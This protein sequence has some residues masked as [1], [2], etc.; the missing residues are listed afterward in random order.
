MIRDGRR[1]E[2]AG[3]LEPAVAVRRAHHGNLDALIAQA[4]DTSGPFSFDRGPSFELEA[5]LAKEI[6]RP[7]EVI[8]DDSLCCPSV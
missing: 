1:R 2:K 6:Y 7:F 3:E 8:D 4:S 5:E